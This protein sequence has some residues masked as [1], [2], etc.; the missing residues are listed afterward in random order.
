MRK[1]VFVTI[2]GIIVVE[3]MFVFAGL[4][5]GFVDVS[6]SRP[7][8][9]LGRWFLATARDRSIR[10]RAAN[11]SVPP[12]DDTL[13]VSKGFDHYNE[14]CVS[15]HGAPGREPDEIAMGL[16][17][18][19]PVLTQSSGGR[20]AA[21]TFLIIKNG[22]KMTGM[23]AWGP[24]HDDSTIWAMVAF[25]RRLPQITPEQYKQMQKTGRN[26]EMENMDRHDHR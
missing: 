13:L 5:S 9:G 10:L 23:P 18:P 26:E 16:N 24:T 19:A 11:I 8:G 21:E 20:G 7:E 17:P 2:A 15:C 1:P 12:L 4:Y 3:I 6:A 25:V 22:I 14:M